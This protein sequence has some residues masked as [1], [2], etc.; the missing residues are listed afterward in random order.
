MIK[1]NPVHVINHSNIRGILSSR[2]R[3]LDNLESTTE[4]RNL[5]LTRLWIGRN[6]RIELSYEAEAIPEFYKNIGLILKKRK[7]I[8]V[9]YALKDEKPQ[10]FDDRTQLAYYHFKL[11]QDKRYEVELEIKLVSD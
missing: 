1:T 2:F 10:N 4:I 3:E 8:P 9:R 5:V 11:Q 7:I 6:S